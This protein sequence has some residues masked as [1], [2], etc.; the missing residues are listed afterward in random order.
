[1]S[2]S[3]ELQK[4]VDELQIAYAVSCDIQDLNRHITVTQRDLTIVSQNIR[5]VYC[6]IDDLNIML[7]LLKF[8]PD[9]IILSECRID[10][11]KHIPSILNYKSYSTT[12]H[13]NQSDGVIVYIKADIAVT[14]VKEIMLQQASCIQIDTNNTAILGIYRSPSNV[15][16]DQFINSLNLHLDTLKRYQNIVLTGDI[17]INIIAEECKNC[18]EH[19]NRCHYLDTLAVHGLLPGH[20]LPTRKLNCLDHFMLKLD[21]NQM[22]ANIA[23][24]NTSI[25]DHALIF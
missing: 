9:V 13:I 1:M 25:T 2:S 10:S 8:S 3:F 23:V 19:N 12:N 5:S 22:S 16:A 11:S 18:N 20:T 21:K 7:S 6:N 24:L 15:K 17:N 4:L 14:K